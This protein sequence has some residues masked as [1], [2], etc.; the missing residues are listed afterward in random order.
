MPGGGRFATG[1]RL[2]AYFFYGGCRP[3]TEIPSRA[4]D[5]HIRREH[6]WSTR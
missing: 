3:G 1:G 5:S 6:R 2:G 4:P